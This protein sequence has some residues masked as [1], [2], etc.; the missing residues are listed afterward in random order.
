M[1]CLLISLGVSRAPVARMRAVR[2]DYLAQSAVLASEC[3]L[4]VSPLVTEFVVAPFLAEDPWIS[5]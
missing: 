5:L 1:T 2:V 4:W 3:S